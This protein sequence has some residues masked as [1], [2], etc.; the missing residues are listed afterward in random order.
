MA[1]SA[2]L[3]KELRDKTGAGLMDCKK[4]LV[5]NNGDVEQSVDWLREKGISKAEKKASRIAAEGVAEVKVAGNKG[6]IFEL[7]CETD[8]VAK[9]DK[10]KSLVSKIGDAL[11]N[12]A[13]ETEEDVFEIEVDGKPLKDVLLNETAMIGEKITLRRY[14]LMTKDDNQV[15]GSYIHFGGSIAT[16][17]VLEGADAETAKNIAMHIAASNPQYISR[18]EISEE[19]IK[20]ETEVLKAQALNENAESDKPKPENIIEKMVIGRLNKNFQEICLLSQPY[21]KNPNETIKSYLKS[22]GAS[23]ASFRRLA[24]GEGIEKKEEN[25]AE[26]VM[27]QSR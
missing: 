7:N 1:I 21:V 5:E 26:E 20:H 8:F 11:I 25:F 22:Q 3:V 24:V 2:K 17:V 6:V 9:N 19:F 4:A 16:L 27:S 10:F 13:K 18:N 14:E 15:F 12:A 23:V